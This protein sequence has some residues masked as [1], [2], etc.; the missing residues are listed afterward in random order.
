MMRDGVMVSI[1][2]AGGMIQEF[3]L[4]SV[5]HDAF[6]AGIRGHFMHGGGNGSMTRAT[7]SKVPP[8]SIEGHV[9]FIQQIKDQQSIV[10]IS[11]YSTRA[12]APWFA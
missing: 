5:L 4:A 12:D 6:T 11:F 2:G 10:D 1:Q 7:T 9:F 3:L 8:P